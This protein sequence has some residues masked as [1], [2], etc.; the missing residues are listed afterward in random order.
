MSETK[1]AKIERVV[2]VREYEGQ[3]GKTFYFNLELDN[4]DIGS[5]GKKKADAL[6]EG[7]VLTYT[8]EETERGNKIKEALQNGFQGG[9]RGFAGASRG[10]NE[11]FALSYAKDTVC[12]LIAAGHTPESLT[13]IQIAETTCKVA[14]IFKKWLD[15]NKSL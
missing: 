8:L 11:S 6:K 14:D 7:D 5:I 3:Y 9:G 10:A 15:D 1:T 12:A 13:S 2:S 4:G